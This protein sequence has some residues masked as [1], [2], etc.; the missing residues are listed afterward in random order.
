MIHTVLLV[1]FGWQQRLYSEG[2]AFYKVKQREVEGDHCIL[3][4]QQLK[5]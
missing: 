5:C 1:Y 2:F 4:Q 3:K